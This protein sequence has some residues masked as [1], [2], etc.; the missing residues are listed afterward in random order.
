MHLISDQGMEIQKHK[1]IEQEL[2]LYY[3]QLLSEPPIDRT[4]AIE[5]I[6]KH[7]PKEVTKEQNEALMPPITQEEVDQAL[8]DTPVGK[9]LGP[10]HFTANFFHHYWDMIREEVWEIIEDSRRSRQVLPSLNATFLALIPKENKVTTLN[11]FRPVALCNVIYKL[12]TKVIAKCL[13][14]IIPFIISQEQSGYMEGRQIM[15]NIILAHEV[16]HS[17][18]STKSPGMLMKLD[19]PKAFDKLR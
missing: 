5:S 1:D 13:K 10:D 14:I 4:Q 19:L 9:S 3:K 6:I 18:Q 2:I 16:I 12:L 15:D 7:I 17:L 11:H 8:R